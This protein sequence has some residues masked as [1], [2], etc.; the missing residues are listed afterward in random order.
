MTGAALEREV[1]VWSTQLGALAADEPR[2]F[3]TLDARERE[4]ASRFRFA[5]D[6]SAYVISHGVL[7]ELLARYAGRA[8]EL[9]EFGIGAWGK[10]YLLEPSGRRST[11]AFSL[12]HSADYALVALARNRAVGVDVER[13]H[14]DS[15]VDAIAE[16]CFS[17]AE[18]TELRSL[19][20]SLRDA[21]FHAGWTRKEAYV[22][23]LGV[24]IRAGLDHFD[25]A[26]GPQPAT[27]LIDD[28]RRKSN[29]SRWRLIDVPMVK[30]YSAALCAEGSDWLPR[31][32]PLALGG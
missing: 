19:A 28:R 16:T 30:G 22:K 9:L 6:R 27:L 21:G 32:Y 7:R 2:F 11:F 8:P 4:R 26:L 31:H 20:P 5:R 17:S 25:V 3:G 1:H 10:P 12:S 29:V 13:W 24:G 15:D 23:A 14:L 18:R